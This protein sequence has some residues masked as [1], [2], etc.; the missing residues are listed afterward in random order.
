MGHRTYL[1]KTSKDK[2][3]ELFEANNSIPFFWLTLIDLD[4]V[5]KTEPEMI[6]V[7]N[8]NEEQYEAYAEQDSSS[9]TLKISKTDFLKNA[10]EGAKFIN[11][12]FSKET[13][14][15]HD[16]ISYLDL[17]FDNNDVLELALMEMADFS[18]IHLLIKSLKEEINAIKNDN[19]NEVAYHIDGN[20]FSNLTGYDRFLSD[21]FKNH[22]TDYRIACDN[23]DLARDIARRKNI[24][25]QQQTIQKEKR[26]NNYTGFLMLFIGLIFMCACVFMIT[27]EGITLQTI[28]T[29]IFCLAIL[30]GGYFKLRH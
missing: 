6:K 30:A 18:D 20:I 4:T 17:T 13:A 29:L 26:S 12:H 10:A 2:S 9:T 1:I 8:L 27:K 11:K 16:F 24:D 23:E 5:E 15:Y 14:L 28:S 7:D 3:K 22:S 25:T 19:A 21:K